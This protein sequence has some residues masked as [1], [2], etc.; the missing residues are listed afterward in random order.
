MELYKAIYKKGQ[1]DNL[2]ILGEN[3][4]KNNRNK[5]F[6]IVRNKKFHL[7]EF[8]PNNDIDKDKIK[9]KILLMRNINNYNFMFKDCETLETL[10]TSEFL[11]TSETLEIFEN[12]EFLET[13][14]PLS[15]ASIINDLHDFILGEDDIEKENTEQIREKKISLMNFPDF[16][17]NSPFETDNNI[18]TI[19][20]F[21]EENFIDTS[22][23]LFSNDNKII[24]FTKNFI[25]LK[26]MFYNCKSLLSLPD[27]S[28]WNTYYVNDMSGIYSNCNS[29]SSLP[30]IS[31]WNTIY[32]IDISGMFYYCSSLISLPDISKWNTSNVIDMKGM[33]SKCSSL[34]SLPEISNWNVNKVEIM[35]E[36]FSNCSSLP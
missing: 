25:L 11:E 1:G 27:F 7:K 20:K 34:S 9:I 28:N 36:M 10:E 18:S 13:F 15:K 21:S 26:E 22:N 14:E 17:D 33:F 12:S 4:V 8:L 31:N 6:L 16:F 35:T 32:V 2:R 5:G 29:L 24:Y 19:Q 30:D 3:Y 23:F